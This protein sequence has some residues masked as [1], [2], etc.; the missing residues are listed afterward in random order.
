MR[1]GCWMLKYKYQKDFLKREFKMPVYLQVIIKSKRSTKP[2]SWKT[3]VKIL[4]NFIIIKM[5]R[6]I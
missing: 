1:I 6:Y 4:I 5:K 3:K 2:T